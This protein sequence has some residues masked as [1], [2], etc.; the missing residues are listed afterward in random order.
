MAGYDTEVAGLGRVLCRPA[1]K[2]EL[3][4]LLAEP[5]KLLRWARKG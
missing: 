5:R 4:L 2:L 3:Y 1:T